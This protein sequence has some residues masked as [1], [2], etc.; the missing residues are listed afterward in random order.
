MPDPNL[1][2]YL[3]LLIWPLGAIALFKN[4]PVERALVWSLLIPLMILPREAEFDLPLIPTLDKYSLSAITAFALCWGM[5]KDRI[6]LLPGSRL[7]TLMMIVYLL[8]P[9]AAALTNPEPLFYGPGVIPGLRLYDAISEIMIHAITLIPFVLGYTILSQPGG[10]REL[11]AAYVVAGLIYT[12]PILIELRLS[13]QINYWVYGVFPMLFD[14]QV[15]WGGYRPVVIMGHSLLVAFF[16]MMTVLAAATLIRGSDRRSFYLWSFLYLFVILVLCKGTGSI[17]FTLAFAPIIMFAGPR[18]KSRLILIAAT[19]VMTYPILRG[20]DAVPVEAFTDYAARLSDERAQS[21]QYRFDNEERL[22]EHASRKPVFGWGFW[23]RNHLY[24][25]FG[26]RATTTDGYWTIIIGTL[27][28]VGYICVFGLLTLPLFRLSWHRAKGMAARDAHVV[29][30]LALMLTV[31]ALDL[32]PNAAIN[33]LT[34]LT[35]GVVLAATLKSAQTADDP[36]EEPVSPDR[37]APPRFSRP[38]RA[39]GPAR[40][41]ESPRVDRPRFARTHSP[42]S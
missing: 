36:L 26:R 3:M 6:R 41:P 20:M 17:L 2:A 19:I 7:T 12:V 8:S 40:Q 24:D 16:M 38:R 25:E 9:I 13:P 1:F 32:L 37:T 18:F 23:G 10:R 30:G 11:L 28:W 33:Y 42:D 31:N 14:Q 21:L 29:Y 27:G 15:R 22:L 5:A 4:L 35:A 34:W 39:A